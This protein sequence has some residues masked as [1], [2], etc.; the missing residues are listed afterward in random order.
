MSVNN[1]EMF[2]S[3]RIRWTKVTHAITKRSGISYIGTK[4]QLLPGDVIQVGNL[5]LKYKVV[6]LKKLEDRPQGYIYRIKRVDGAFITSTDI[7]NVLVGQKVQIVSNKTFQQIFEQH[8]DVPHIEICPVEI[9]DTE[10][11]CPTKPIVVTPITPE[12]PTICH[13]YLITLPAET[14][15]T[16]HYKNCSGVQED[17][18]V[19][20]YRTDYTV[21]RCG[22][23]GQTLA[24]IYLS[25][26][27]SVVD[28]IFT[29][30]EQLC[31]TGCEDS[32]Q[33]SAITC[34][35]VNVNLVLTSSEEVY[36]AAVYYSFN[37]NGVDYQIY[38]QPLDNDFIT[39][40]LGTWYLYSYGINSDIASLSTLTPCPTGAF[41]FVGGDCVGFSSFIVE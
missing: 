40:E 12:P 25:D 1:L 9:P 35:G 22:I 39:P 11:C 18:E 3:V 21:V 13:Q 6:S 17:E 20:N 7:N 27:N 32:I 10:F 2:T 36:G 16:F 41:T 29:E 30:T 38:N 24:D 31:P 37:Y 23:I 5:G 4:E 8:P 15:G 19:G 33:A 34:L 28:L 26:G 14:P